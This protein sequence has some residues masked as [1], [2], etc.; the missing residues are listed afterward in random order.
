MEWLTVPE[1]AGL[2]GVKD[3]T[4]RA[5]IHRGRLKALKVGRDWLIETNEAERYRK[6]NARQSAGDR[7]VSRRHRA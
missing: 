4:V 3:S 7:G 6:E 2:L 5:Q 1:M